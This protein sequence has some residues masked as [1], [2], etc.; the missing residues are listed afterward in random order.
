MS[1]DEAGKLV[2]EKFAVP[3]ADHQLFQPAHEN[4]KLTLGRWMARDRTLEYY[5]FQNNVRNAFFFFEL[6]KT[7]WLFFFS[8]LE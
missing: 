2:A 4:D 5:Q 3:S 6:V 1:V 8:I 7:V